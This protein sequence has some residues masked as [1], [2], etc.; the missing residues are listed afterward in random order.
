MYFKEDRILINNF[1]RQMQVWKLRNH[2]FSTCFCHTKT[3]QTLNI[4]VFTQRKRVGYWHPTLKLNRWFQCL[5][6]PFALVAVECTRMLRPSHS[7]VFFIQQSKGNILERAIYARLKCVYSMFLNIQVPVFSIKY[8]SRTGKSRFIRILRQK[9]E[10]FFNVFAF[11]I[12]TNINL[13][14]IFRNI[15][16]EMKL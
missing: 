14:E 7:Y 9:S 15:L 4:F 10:I 3:K 2:K 12:Y 8:I 16:S 11:L 5:T 6:I 13:T 1:N